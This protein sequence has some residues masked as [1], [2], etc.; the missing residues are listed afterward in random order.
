[1]PSTRSDYWVEK[2]K[3]NV[4][5]YSRV[6]ADLEALGWHVVAVWECETK[7]PEALSRFLRQRILE[8][9]LG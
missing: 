4:A 6:V 7:D 3:A 2:F 8:R 1:M 9:H 5:R